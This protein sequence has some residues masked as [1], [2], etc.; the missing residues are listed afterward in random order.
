MSTAFHILKDHQN[1]VGWTAC[2]PTHAT[3]PPIRYHLECGGRA[4]D[5]E[6]Q[7]PS[8]RG[9]R[10][11]CARRLGIESAMRARLLQPAGRRAG[12]QA[13]RVPPPNRQPK[14]WPL[15]E[16]TLPWPDA[17]QPHAQFGWGRRP[18]S[19]CKC[20]L[21]IKSGPIHVAPGW[22]LPI[23]ENK[24]RWPG[25]TIPHTPHK[26]A[27]TGLPFYLYIAGAAPALL[28]GCFLAATSASSGGF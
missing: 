16:R 2:A 27:G 15:N 17:P 28:R 12:R 3:T 26:G 23:S 14:V 8:S 6:T 20:Q 18:A 5:M 22:G 25:P 7:H 13:G 24:L 19:P 10:S 9:R 1:V 21:V 11:G 4:A